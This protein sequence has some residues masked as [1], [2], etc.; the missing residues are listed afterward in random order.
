MHALGYVEDQ[1]I[2]IE[3]RGAAGQLEHLPDLASELLRLNVDLIVVSGYAAT[4]AARQ[5]TTTTPIVFSTHVDPVGTGLV[6]SLAR[7]GGNATGI[8]LFSPVLVGKRLE[9]LKE[10]VPEIS[11]VAVLVNTANPGFEPTLQQMEVA[12]QALGLELHLLEARAPNELDSIASVAAEG[13]RVG[14]HVNLD[15]LYLDHRTRIVELAATAG[16]PAMYDLREFVAA[17]GLMAYG[18]R[19]AEMWGRNAA[20]VDTILKGAKPADLPVEQPMRL[21]FAI[22]LRTAQALGLTIP[23][24]VLLQATE[25]IQ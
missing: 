20:Q 24:R 8:T 10:A 11:R 13:R 23:D 7:P 21:D 19:L 25:I 14:L 2:S 18:P 3:A 1:N 5:A 17:G 6:G 15:P 22:N 12:A 9:L 16:V 4:L